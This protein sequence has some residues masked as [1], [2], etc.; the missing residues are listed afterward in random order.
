MLLAPNRRRTRRRISSVK[1]GVSSKDYC[2]HIK[3]DG[4]K[5]ADLNPDLIPFEGRGRKPAAELSENQCFGFLH[6]L[7]G[8]ILARVATGTDYGHGDTS[9]ELN[10]ISPSKRWKASIRRSNGKFF[11]TIPEDSTGFEA[12]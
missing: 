3:L 11:Q 10:A 1:R 9:S 5:N 6:R 12:S 2:S 4:W 7:K 8:F